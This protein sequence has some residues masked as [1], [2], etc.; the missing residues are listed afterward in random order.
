MPPRG[1]RRRRSWINGP[2]L[3]KLRQA[4]DALNKKFEEAVSRRVR[5]VVKPILDGIRANQEQLDEISTWIPQTLDSF[6]QQVRVLTPRSDQRAPPGR[7]SELRPRIEAVAKKVAELRAEIG[8]MGES[9]TGESLARK[10]EQAREVLNGRVLELMEATMYA[11]SDKL[12]PKIDALSAELTG[13]VRAAGRCLD[14]APTENSEAADE[15]DQ[16]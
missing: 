3:A 14:A 2:G 12:R 4:M 15:S 6:D 7:I 11:S 8:R 9:P 5:D 16:K 13:K 1:G 10:V